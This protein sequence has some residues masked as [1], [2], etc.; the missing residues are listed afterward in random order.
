MPNKMFELNILRIF[1]YFV[2]FKSVRSQTVTNV[3]FCVTQ[4]SCATIG[5]TGGTTGG[6]DGTGSF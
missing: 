3:C 6:N 2:I 4:G 1:V 5:G